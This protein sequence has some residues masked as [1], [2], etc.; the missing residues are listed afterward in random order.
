MTKV[1]E[2]AHAIESKTLGE[3]GKGKERNRW[4]L[5]DGVRVLRV[6]YPNSHSGDLK[7]GTLESIRKQLKLDPFDFKHSLSARCLVQHT[8][9]IFVSLKLKACFKLS[10]AANLSYAI[11]SVA[12]KF[13]FRGAPSKQQPLPVL[14]KK[15]LTFDWWCNHWR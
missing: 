15:R 9:S 6:T 13:G 10:G 8:T 2:V 1:R 3:D 7:R 14:I 12:L 5:I 4:I 11:T